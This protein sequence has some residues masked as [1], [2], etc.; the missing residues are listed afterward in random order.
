MIEAKRVY[1]RPIQYTDANTIFAYRSLECVAQYQYWEP[2]TM[3]KSLDFVEQ[4]S[5][6]DISA[7][8]VWIGLAIIL[9]SSNELIGDCALKID[10]RK[11]ELGCNISPKH[12]RHGYAQ[13]ALNLLIDMC[14]EKF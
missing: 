13:D 1:I 14:F 12:Q 6:L 2:F 5:C 4:N 8:G 11:A 7:K 10:G 9:K 3:Q